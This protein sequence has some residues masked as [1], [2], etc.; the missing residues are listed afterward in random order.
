[1]RLPAKSHQDQLDRIKKNVEF[2]AEYFRKNAE[3]YKSS[4]EFI[5]HDTITKDDEQ[6]LQALELPLLRCNVLEPFISRLRGEFAQNHPSLKVFSPNQNDPD[7]V[8]MMPVI[9]G[10]LRNI[11]YQSDSDN[12]DN[13]TI[14]NMLSGGFHVLRVHYDYDNEASLDQSL[15]L[16]SVYDPTLTGFDPEAIKKHKGDGKYCYTLYPKRLSELKQEYSN[17]SFL[18]DV[19]RLPFAKIGGDSLNWSWKDDKNQEKMVLLCEYFEKVY[20]TVK[21]VKLT[22]HST[23]TLEQFE[24]M[25][26]DYDPSSPEVE[27][28][29]V[30]D[31]VSRRVVDHV[32]RYV[33][34]GNHVLEQEKTIYTDLPLVFFDGNGERIGN[35]HITRAYTYNAKDTQ[36]ARNLLFNQFI[37]EVQNLRKTT[38]L[39]PEE[40]LP[41]TGEYLQ[42]YLNPNKAKAALI[43]KHEKVDP[44]TNDVRPIPQPQVFPRSPVP[45]E[46]FS[47]F[48]ALKSEIQSQLGAYDSQ[49][50]IQG[51]ELSGRAIIAGST[52][53]NAAAK[54]YIIN[55][56]ASM[57]QVA[58]II[59]RL[60][61]KIYNTPRTIPIVM[62]D[63]S[64]GYQTI[65]ND[66]DPNSISLEFE[67]NELDIIIEEGVNFETE[68]QQAVQDLVNLSQAFPALG[69]MV[70]TPAGIE[71]LLNNL[72]FKGVEELKEM[73]QQQASEPPQP[74][75]PNPQMIA[76][77]NM[78]QQNQLK[79]EEL[80]MKNQQFMANLEMEKAKL[81]AKIDADQ[82]K[83]ELA[84]DRQSL[85]AVNQALEK[86]KFVTN[87]IHDLQREYNYG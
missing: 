58:K 70:N 19:S 73:A 65:N 39:A 66:D 37:D 14:T 40:A 63:G 12:V 62:P 55:Y 87:H 4:K 27:P 61:P 1:M 13:E 6:N 53:A 69:S 24:Q 41:T 44:Q 78:A 28:E 45:P 71:V 56:I 25:V 79:Q 29:M 18:S 32:H 30:G 47:A 2:A 74:P 81:Q 23:V 52:Q 21:L 80:N 54:P 82:T 49:L 46:L 16:E 3:H 83:A 36:R 38:I 84:Q 59:L 8:A 34:A 64:R 9:S 77:Q 7:N 67:P 26:K 75:Q 85:E 57:N 22:N 50:G 60:I 20:K 17:D 10:I 68:R 43:Y 33:I 35:K 31:P 42:A 11:M 76:A 48:E 15:Y 86:Y 72:N 51:N 5:F